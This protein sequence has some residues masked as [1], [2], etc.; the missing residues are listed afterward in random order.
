M[1][2][3]L[4]WIWSTDFAV[5]ASG[6]QTLPGFLASAGKGSFYVI[7]SA[8]LVYWLV[9]RNFQ[10][11][12]RTNA[13]LRAITE[14]T[15]DAVFVKDR[16]GK[17][18]LCN[19]ATASFVGKS[20][21]EILGE[22]DTA[23]FESASATS[24]MERDRRIMEGDWAET[25]EEEVRAAGVTRV[26]LSTKAP[27]RDESG[28]VAG[29]IGISRDVTER[30]RAQSVIREREEFARGVLD[31][32]AAHVSV[33]N[34]AGEIIAVNELWRLFASQNS[35]RIGPS[36]R[37]HVG[38][39]YLE[40]CDESAL[41]GCADAAAAAAGI[42]RVI[43]GKTDRFTLEYPCHSAEERRWFALSATRLEHAS[44]GVV[45]AH[46]NI[47]ELKLAEEEI[48]E[49]RDRLTRIAATVPGVIHSFRLSPDGTATFPYASPAIVHIYGFQPEELA[50]DASPV[51]AMMPPEDAARTLASIRSSA[52]NLTP[53]REVFRIR[54]P[55]RGEIWLEG[56]STPTREP[57]G[58]TLWHG[59]LTEVT[60]RKR[61]E[62]ELRFQH[63]LLKSQAEA[64]PD[65]ILVVG[66]DN[67]VLSYNQ[68]ILKI[69][70][71]PEAEAERGD[72]KR[73]VA[74]ALDLAADPEAF[75]A[76]VAAVAADPDVRTEGELA[77]SDGR[78]LVWHS[79]PIRGDD[80]ERFGRVWFFR[81]V[82]EQLTARE[83]VRAGE[84]RL[85]F[86]IE[87]VPAPIAMLD[88]DMRYLHVSRRWLTD[89]G[90]ADRDIA[91]LS[92][93]ELFPELPELPERWK[94]I[95]RRCMAGAVEG[96]EEDSFERAN[97]AVQWLR[98]EVRP[99]TQSDGS[100]GGIIIFSEE[101][102]KRHHA[103][104]ALRESEERYRNLVEVLPLAILIEAGDAIVF[105][106][107]A[108]VSLMG[109]EKPEDLLGKSLASLAYVNDRACL[110]NC[111]IAVHDSGAGT[112]LCEVR[113]LHP[114]GRTIPVSL[115]TTAI[116]GAEGTSTLFA[117]AD[118]SER[119]RSAALLRSVMASVTDAILTIDI[120]G[121]VL[122][123][124]P[125]TEKLFGYEENELV[126][127]NFTALMPEPYRGEHGTYINN[128]VR[129]GVA[130]VIGIGREVVG[131]RKNGTTFPVELTV[132]EFQFDGQPRFTGVLRDI[133]A[134]RRLEAE[135]QQAQKM[136]AVGRLAGGVAHD[137]NNLLTIINGYCSLLLDE[138][139][140]GNAQREFVAAIGEAGE[141]AARLTQQL[142]A[143][144]RK[145]VVEAQVFDLNELCAESAKFLRRLIGED[146][147]LA[148][149]PDHEAVWIKADPGQLE[150]VIMNL[151]VNARDAMPTGGRLTIESR[152][153]TIDEADLRSAGGP[154]VGRYGLLRVADTGGG[155]NE[156]TKKKIFEPFFTTK[157]VGK[158]T[159]LGLAVV[160]GV[161]EQFG[162][163]VTVESQIGV[164]T[165]FNLYFPLAAEF[166]AG[167]QGAGATLAVRGTE[168]VLLV[169]DEDAVRN[170]VRLA[171]TMQG[172][173]VLQASGGEEAIQLATAHK[174]PIHLL[175][176]DVVMPEMSGRR[177]AEVV[178]RHRPE[179]P[180]LFM[181]GYT[182][183]AV[184]N[185]GVDSSDAFIQKP[186]TP[187]AL[188]RKVRAVLSETGAQ[189]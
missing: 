84:A 72:N 3:G 162:G 26:Y 7:A 64:S 5:F 82:T 86:C 158:G 179:I 112:R 115:L 63:A 11:L 111:R 139:E 100:I 169:E 42:R 81:D 186:F 62:A 151:A 166:A 71:I 129:T 15:T 177:L 170:I 123:A 89:F 77:L 38:T 171:L 57:D 6:S 153:V 161:V 132:S 143:F 119:E 21:E 107:P 24:I 137:F 182:E 9:Q 147:A 36:P 41:H 118:L 29:M 35:A 187:Q 114:D 30:Q 20:I 144:S 185:H 117:M 22:D 66:P 91:G 98:W 69:W 121:T 93:Y 178:R 95:N 70:G 8:A 14:G 4:L 159:G 32:M 2:F 110:R 54:R 175:V 105:C 17:Y 23:L 12:V 1:A 160:H 16:A 13:L 74:M 109:A 67:R 78:H 189:A 99:W 51:F 28:E 58:G 59:F 149:V 43:A 56:Y 34:S 167:P 102:T 176:T 76:R 173:T 101:I 122:S 46:T 65:G 135:F 83:A 19:P 61:N 49:Q 79:G 87:H 133:T 85:R 73:L 116:G 25:Y 96:S 97:G 90:L 31:S 188:A 80:G 50:R 155:F 180:V 48:R 27:F 157:A 152:I 124:N 10:A 108:F 39:N 134:R 33:L 106:N 113:V 145:A 163:Y 131:L 103:E 45:V 148:V 88:R 138:A 164:G 184:V 183:E 60:E 154:P 40:V 52:R 55:G 141:R 53:W 44:A 47:T 120:Q 142:L 126:G 165:T 156:E 168:T 127:R 146:I 68:R 125:A 174:G 130:K 150:Q 75:S 94:E 136:E 181:S 172:F 104:L 92:H 140:T 37:T 128:Y 18:L